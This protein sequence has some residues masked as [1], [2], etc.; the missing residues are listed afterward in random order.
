NNNTSL[1]YYSNLYNQAGSN[2]TIIGYQAGKGTALHNK[3]GNVFLGYMAGYSEHGSNKLYIENSNSSTPLIYGEFDND[4]LGVNGSLGIGTTSPSEKLEVSGNIKAS[5]TIQSGSSIVIDGTGTTQGTI[6]ES[7]GKIS[8][9]DDTL[10]TTG[11]I[12]T[13]TNTPESSAQLEVKSISKGFLQPRMTTAQRDSIINPAEG[14][15][16]YNT[17]SK[18]LNFYI[19]EFWHEVCGI[20]TPQPTPADAGSNQTEVCLSTTISANDPN[21][22]TGS[23]TIE[24][25]SGGN[26]TT[27]L[28]P[29][30]TFSGADGAAYTLRWTISTICTTDYDEV[31]ISFAIFPTANAGG[32]VTI[33]YGGNTTLN[34]SGS[35]GTAPSYSWNTGTTNSS[36]NVSPGVTTTYTV[37]VSNICGS[38][39]DEVTVTVHYAPTANAGGDVTIC[40]GGNTL[41]NASGST[42]TA[43][44]S[45][46]WNTGATSPSLNVTP[47]ATTTYTVTVTNSC[48]SDSDE[49]TVTVH[50]APTANAG[51]DATICSGANTTLNASGSTGTSPLSYSW[52]FGA[53]SP[54][55]NVNLG[56]TT[57]Y[58]V[59][60]TNSCGSDSDEVTVKTYLTDSRDGK[61]YTIT[62]IG[63]QCWMAENLAYLPSVNPSNSSS[64]SY[65][66]YYVYDY[67][68][69]DVN[70][71]KTHTSAGVG[72]YD[73][74]GVL[75]NWPAAMAG[76]SS[77]NTVPSGVQGICTAG[78][79][80]PGDEE[81]K[82]LE[83]AVDGTYGYPDA[84]WDKVWHRGTDAGANLKEVGTNHWYTP[85]NGATNSSGFTALPGGRR[86]S[87][88][89]FEYITWDG[90]FWSSTEYGA[91]QSWYR[92]MHYHHM[93]VY[94]DY[95]HTKECGFSVRCLKD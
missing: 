52:N 73:E 29:T 25:G 18:C 3:Y 11:S 82:V 40:N 55:V 24:S 46:S 60:V 67:E 70:A 43:P 30:S 19:G 7:H 42:G 6:T 14:L 57:T 20:C 66:R 75:Y 15:Q 5:G 31:D 48:G 68:G 35:T 95:S 74:Y 2:N 69:T 38:D 12:G 17:D 27:P 78:W 51:G 45:Y 4:I 89:L 77:S 94:R 53:T 32:D 23:W 16:I 83:G 49:V 8:F 59:T 10:V 13:G 93:T 21:S 64:D 79:H 62:L 50:Y 63:S 1:G 90:Y 39:S 56:I 92:F 34:A 71:A 54:S 86:Y 72:M 87:N 81:W 91:D 85:N 76:S 47:N 22:G 65:P 41:L 80:L 84:E 37:T 44:L 36:L 26:V 33:C 61:N 58:T 88:D 9:D 28:S